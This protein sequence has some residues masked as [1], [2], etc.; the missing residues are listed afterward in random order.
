M[1]HIPYKMKEC[2]H[3]LEGLLGFMYDICMVQMFWD[4]L[5]MAEECENVKV[6]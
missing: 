6:V 3:T 1:F 2:Q 4:P 5:K